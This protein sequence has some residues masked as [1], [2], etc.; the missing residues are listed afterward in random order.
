MIDI[1]VYGGGISGL[2]TLNALRNLGYDAHLFESGEMGAGQ[3]IAS[4]GII[5]GGMK[6]ALAGIME[7]QAKTLGAMPNRWR[8]CLRGNGE[9]DLRNV[10]VLCESQIM[11]FR[12]PLMGKVVS[13]M[14]GDK[15][16]HAHDTVYALREPVLDVKSLLAS[17][18]NNDYIYHAS[19][20]PVDAKLVI[21][22]SGIGNERITYKGETQRRPL[23]MIMWKGARY[24]LFTHYVGL[25]KKPL[26][27]IT[28]HRM[29]GEYVWYIGGGIAE[30]AVKKF[31]PLR[32]A[33][34]RL[35]ELRPD[36]LWSRNGWAYHDVDRAEPSNEHNE[37]PA[38]P[39]LKI[40]GN[41]AVAWPSKLAM[42]PALSDEI[43]SWVKSK[44]IK[45]THR[46]RLDLPK[47]SI[48]QYPWERAKW[49]D[50]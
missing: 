49:H 3:T 27:T 33:Y 44:G 15:M 19:D 28:S 22:V 24:P 21:Y 35:T 1:A 9:I 26:F 13:F 34:N 37:L 47:P 6:Y 5:H 14:V 31:N 40:S 43:V 11:E 16:K 36:I 10:D 2:W 18:S 23:R 8:E 48:A 20:S 45:P 50:I 42:A 30:D 29:N 4:Q 25:S 41:T 46:P 12:Y 32:Y 38:G 17:L 39:V 7:P